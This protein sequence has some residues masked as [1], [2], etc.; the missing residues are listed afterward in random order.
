M[1]IPG[2]DDLPRAAI[3]RA[4][5]Q[6][7]ARRNQWTNTHPLSLSGQIIIKQQQQQQQQHQPAAAAAASSS[8]QQPAAAAAQE[9]ADFHQNITCQEP[10]LS[11]P[12][13]NQL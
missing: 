4:P 7:T 10:Q 6:P 2:I 8:Q 9:T 5:R 3:R 12:Q 1:H 13:Q 11:K